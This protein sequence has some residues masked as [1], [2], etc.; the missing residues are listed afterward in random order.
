VHAG[1]VEGATAGQGGSHG[2]ASRWGRAR[3]WREEEARDKILLGAGVSRVRRPSIQTFS[4]E[5]YRFMIWFDGLH[6]DTTRWRKI[7]PT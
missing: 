5:H 6:I 7:L 3:A 2:R 1:V 4:I